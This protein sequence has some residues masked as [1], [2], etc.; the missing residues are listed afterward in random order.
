MKYNK[1]YYLS[2]EKIPINCYGSGYLTVNGGEWKRK[3]KLP[4]MKTNFHGHLPPF[5][6][7][8]FNMAPPLPV[9]KFTDK[10]VI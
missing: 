9:Q 5:D 4:M 1:A 8:N 2:I 7:L 6:F 10:E 3:V